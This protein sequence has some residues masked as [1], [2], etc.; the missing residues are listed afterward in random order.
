MSEQ[1]ELTDPVDHSVGGMYGHLFRRGFHVGM[2]V[3]PFVYYEYAEKI[4]DYFSINELQLVSFLTLAIV[5][6]E[7]VRLK[8]GITIFGQRDYESHQVSALAWG[9]FAVGLTFLLLSEHPEFVWP[10]ILSLSLG[11]PFLGEV[12]RKGQEPKT[13]FILGSIFI[14]LIWV[15][16]WMQVG[17]PLWMAF[18]MAP[19]CV[20][21]EWPRLRWIDDNATMLLIP[22][23]AVIML[24][25]W[26]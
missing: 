4:S 2:S 9:G 7:A 24:V 19:I 26:L 5:F 22:L 11:D 3:L 1:V 15:A 8:L 6:S 23:A 21:A 10:L 18:V 20:A 12:R 14:A 13:V 17:T 25:P 16:C